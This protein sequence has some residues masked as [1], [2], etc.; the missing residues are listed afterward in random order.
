MEDPD[1]N[2]KQDENFQKCLEEMKK[3]G[4][5][6]I[7]KP[8]NIS[9]KQRLF[10]ELIQKANDGKTI[11]F[12]E[13]EQLSKSERKEFEEILSKMNIDGYSSSSY[14]P[15]FFKRNKIWIIPISTALVI[16]GI[17]TLMIIIRGKIKI[18]LNRLKKSGKKWRKA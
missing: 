16:V 15:S 9:K 5:K 14:E 8:S 13:L 6:H 1:S 18:K 4:S 3:S 12:S 17:L 11:Y 7:G 10:L 2:S